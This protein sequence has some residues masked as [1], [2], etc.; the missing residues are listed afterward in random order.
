MLVR[1]FYVVVTGNLQV[2][3]TKGCL[4]CKWI[5]MFVVILSVLIDRCSAL[6]WGYRLAV[7]KVPVRLNVIEIALSKVRGLIVK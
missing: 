4:H 5:L 3:G 7:F 6:E 2:L 1:L